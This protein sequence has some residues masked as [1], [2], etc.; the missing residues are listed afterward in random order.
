MVEN[1]DLVSIILPV[2]NGEK[3][4]SESIESVIHQSYKNWELL[5]VD[6][7]STDNSAA[8][9]KKYASKDDRIRYYRN[10]RNL[11]LPKNLNRGFSLSRGAYLTWTSD[12]NRYRPSAI[13]TMLRKLHETQAQFAF[14][15]CR[16]IDDA[17]EEIEYI[18][19]DEDS[20]KLIVGRNT[21]GAC[22]LYTREVYETVGDYDPEMELVEDFDYWQR[23]IARF[24]AAAISE[25]LYDYRWHEGA[26]T[27]TMRKERF[28]TNL[29]RMLLKNRPL[30]GKLSIKQKY[31]FYSEL[32]KCRQGKR[33][34]YSI[35]KAF[36][37]GLYLMCYRI[38]G[39]MKRLAAQKRRRD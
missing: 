13:E 26:L 23:I 38:P 9:A 8:I 20:P 15:S 37:S 22:F 25:I 11:R 28:Y 32:D 12:D 10:E 31:C 4:L 24:P 1:Q 3:Y 21:V 39:K 18:S 7:C 6:D 29:E 35:K 33:S 27:S 30:F 5:I 2:Y 36:Y 16:I 34:P 17:G 19:V 14:A